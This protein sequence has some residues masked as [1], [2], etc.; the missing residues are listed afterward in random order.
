MA[1]PNADTLS[2][3][4]PPP[5]SLA[6]SVP[7]A[8][9]DDVFSPDKINKLIQTDK[10]LMEKKIGAEGAAAAELNRREKES[11]DRMEHLVKQ[12]GISADQL[13]PWNQE[14][15]LA[16]HQ[17]SL[18]DQFG[19]PG[20]IIAM[21]GSA[22]SARPMDAALQSGGAALKAIQ[23][24]DQ[25]GYEKAF[26][27]WKTNTDLVIKRQEMQHREFEDLE[28]LRNT[29]IAAWRA[30]TEELLTRFGDERN[31]ALLRQGY[32]DKV[33][34]A[35]SN[36]AQ[37]TDQL[38]I[39][40]N[41]IMEQK[42]I[43]DAVMQTDDWKS[44]DPQRMIKALS[45]VEARM[46]AAKKGFG[47]VEGGAIGE[48]GLRTMVDQYLAGDKS[49]LQNIGRGAQ[50]S[51]NI[52]RFR[53]LLAETMETR[54]I[55]GAD[56]ARRIQEFQAQTAGLAAGE[57]TAASTAANLELIMR[58]AHAAVP[59]ALE[60]SEKV[61]RGKWV[62]LNKLLQTS[63]S[64]ISNPQL[65]EFRVANLQLA[66][67]WAR[68]M[69]PRGVMRE[70]DRQFAL[71]MLSTADSKE[72]YKLVVNQLK[73]FLEREQKSVRDFRSH[74]PMENPEAEAPASDTGWKIERIN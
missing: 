64:S 55:S 24:G 4:Q 7:K 63:E 71:D 9:N 19:S 11:R 36:Q 48:Q 22:F 49:V 72:T 29:D 18:W 45:E 67:L 25:A 56:Q 69:N 40:Q 10:E 33:M 59:A 53:N 66:E 68:A 39:A 23:A 1:D 61:S 50:G 26:D 37:L 44:K 12:E 17:T 14:Q 27:A 51:Q 30:K 42:A 8:A 38:K 60:A 41:G 3:P 65:K 32:D 6:N 46:A 74:A 57:R 58:N 15:E 2:P 21:L 31:L 70:S 13:K 52:A 5:P 28:H 62:P 35:I 34:Q 47:S 20:F 43:S 54:G 73:K 16:K